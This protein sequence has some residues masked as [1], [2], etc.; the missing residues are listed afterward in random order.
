MC[1]SEESTVGNGCMADYKFKS[2]VEQ[3]QLGGLSGSGLIG[4]SPESAEGA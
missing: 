4:L 2:V 3:D 1:L